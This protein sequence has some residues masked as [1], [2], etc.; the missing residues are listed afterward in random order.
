MINNYELNTSEVYWTDPDKFMPERF[1]MEDGSFRKPANFFPF[2]YGKRAC[3]GYQLVEKVTESVL[4]SIL[5]Q[6]D[7]QSM[8]QPTQL[9]LA[10]VAIHPHEHLRLKLIPRQ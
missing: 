8:E 6:F 1:L 10:S 7:I 5:K 9:P 3:M 2:S 4:L